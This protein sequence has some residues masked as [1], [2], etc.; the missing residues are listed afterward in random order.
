[1]VKTIEFTLEKKSPQNAPTFFREILDGNQSL[2]NAAAPLGAARFFFDN[3]SMP[4]RVFPLNF[5]AIWEY[6]EVHAE[7]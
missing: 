2:F 3:L 5:S 1:M 4:L 7:V 6:L